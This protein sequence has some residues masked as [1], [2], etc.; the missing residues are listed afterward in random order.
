[1][2]VREKAGQSLT[3]PV[4]AAEMITYLG[5][6][7]LSTDETTIMQAMITAARKYLEDYT[8]KSVLSKSYEVRFYTEDK[9]GD[10][11]ELP[12]SPVTSITS[13]EVSGTAIDYDEKGQDRIYIRP[14]SSIITNAT[15]DEAYLDCEFVAGATDYMANVAVKRIV[16]DMWDNRKDNLPNSPA[17]GL[18]WETLNYIETLSNNTEL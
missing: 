1:M 3:E 2:Q 7:T 5:L 8:A 17:A 14:Q 16:S 9:I 4:T 13:V 15:T 6:D 12:F 10:Y 18:R 11:Y